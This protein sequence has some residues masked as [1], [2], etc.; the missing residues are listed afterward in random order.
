MSTQSFRFPFGSSIITIGR[1]PDST[2]HLPAVGVSRHH[3]QI[4][5]M[6]DGPHV[7]DSGCSSG[8]ML[9]GVTVAG[10]RLT[11]G[12][13]LTI[14]VIELNVTIDSEGLLL[15]RMESRA[16]EQE[17]KETRRITVGRDKSCVLVL[18]HPAVSRV[19][20]V[21]SA[22][23]SSW[24]LADESSA[25]G[26][27]VN[28]HR[29][30]TTDLFESDVIDIGPF[31]LVLRGNR[32]ESLA[33]GK[34]VRV[35]AT[36]LGV[37]AGR[38]VILTDANLS[39]S[40]GE[41]VA[42]LGKSGAGK[43]TL[44]RALA[45]QV[46][47]AA[48]AVLYNGVSLASKGALNRFGVGYVSQQILLRPE[49]TVAETLHEQAI[50]R[51]PPDADEAEIMVRV[52]TVSGLMSID[53]IADRR[54]ALLSGGEAR[55]V[56]IAVELLASPPVIVLD[57]PLAGLD[58]VLAARFMQ[59]FASLSVQGHTV[60]LVTHHTEHVYKCDRMFF[61][62]E[63]RIVFAG[64]P[65]EAL[66]RMNAADMTQVC[67]RVD[68]GWVDTDATAVE[69]PVM[70][71]DDSPDVKQTRKFTPPRQLAMLSLRYFKVLA[72]DRVNLALML[73][74]P[75]LVAALLALVYPHDSFE[76]P[77][78][79]WFCITIAAIWMGGVNTVREFAREWPLYRRECAVGL[80]LPYY[81][82]SKA[83]VFSALSIVQSLIFSLV[84]AAAFSASP[85]AITSLAIT[86][87][88]A[89]SGTLLGLAISSFGGN[90]Q[91][92]LAVLPIIFRRRPK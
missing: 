80:S 14:G 23:G 7:F 40:P 86:T 79:F 5:F 31:R 3:A 34:S 52:S 36:H 89:L 50:L 4:I 38:H 27:F 37:K 16:T 69:Q 12:N 47:P 88:A 72:R 9:D 92:A 61:I 45:G 8:V 57:E 24:F 66:E 77:I 85:F 13:V 78:S 44:A 59:L 32:L 71:Q 19:H 28:G 54:V 11:D 49:L 1:D 51:L 84:L 15:T 6:S 41:F 29:I 70:P 91:R 33:D 83:A 39:I 75:L 18:D 63:G 46:K 67:E 82:I 42:I 55:R 58:T 26:T 2:I 87:A 90:V 62:S 10:G 74:Q 21:F 43:T 25:N 56:H 48:G 73:L 64:K 60:I 20:C 22:T 76:M 68:L 17:A 30:A 35:D 81:F 65:D 53:G